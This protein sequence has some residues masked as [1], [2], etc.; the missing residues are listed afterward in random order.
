M[1]LAD[2][3]EPPNKR[4]KERE[5]VWRLAVKTRRQQ[6]KTSVSDSVSPLN[7]GVGGRG[8]GRYALRDASEGARGK[9]RR[10]S[11]DRTAE[12]RDDTWG[13]VEPRRN[14]EQDGR[15]QDCWRGM[16][17]GQRS[18]A[19]SNETASVAAIMRSNGGSQ[20]CGPSCRHGNGSR[21]TNTG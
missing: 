20:A 3:Q 12:W 21:M 8:G 15:M 10:V 5:L 4:G 18:P 7:A 2:A 9:S 16:R 19:H 6:Q 11:G 14:E 13:K 1:K 17:S